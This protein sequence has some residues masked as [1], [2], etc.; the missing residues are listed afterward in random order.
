M[1]IGKERTATW[2][3]IL[4]TVFSA[5]QRVIMYNVPSSIPTFAFLCISNLVGFLVLLLFKTGKKKTVS[6][7]AMRK[8]FHLAAVLFFFNL[9]LMLGV[10][11]GNVLSASG[12]LSLFFV[13]VT[14][15]LLILRKRVSYFS[16]IAT[17]VAIVAL[18]LM[19][20]DKTV[21]RM[22]SS[23]FV[24]ILLSD[25]FFAS[26]MVG[27]AVLGEKEDAFALTLSMQGFFT[28]LCLVGWLVECPVKG[29]SFEMPQT[30]AF[31]IPVVLVGI[32]MRALF[33]YIQV[34]AQQKVAPLK[35]SLILSG[36]VVVALIASPVVYTMLGM[37]YLPASPFQWAGVALLV[38]AG[39]MVDE[40]YMAKL[41]YE[42]LQ[43]ME[44]SRKTNQSS[45]SKKIVLTTLT[46][47]LIVAVVS[48][49]LYFVALRYVHSMATVEISTV[50]SVQGV[51]ESAINQLFGV[52]FEVGLLLIGI[53]LVVVTLL[54]GKISRRLSDPIRQLESDVHR[55][56]GGDLSIRTSVQTNDEIGSL[57]E[58]FNS[59]ADSLQKYIED[60]KEITAKEE[61]LAGELFAA[62]TIQESM[63]PQD[64]EKFSEGRNFSI[65]ATMDPAKEVGGDFYDY[66]MVDEDH[67]CLVIAD[68]SGKG[69]P[70]S[71]FMV[72]TKTLIKLRTKLG[73]GPATIL[74]DVNGRLCENNGGGLF[75]TVWLALIELSTGKG[76]AANAGHEHPVVR[77][78]KNGEFQIWKYQHSP[79]VAT[80]EDL[81]FREHEFT[82]SPGDCL[83]VYTDGVPEATNR[84]EELFGE[85]R[86]TNALNRD[87]G[88]PVKELLIRVKDSIDAF[89]G[90]AVQFDDITMLG[91]EYQSQLKEGE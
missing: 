48:I 4:F 72:V 90:D 3:L 13:F 61:R 44:S 12:A 11:G 58:S 87:S 65:Y 66:F 1:T 78:G 36:Q 63:L 29:L 18:T 15:I 41:G 16:L 85:E 69:I 80:M 5:T 64:F 8:G 73:G 20:G 56:S 47:A 91:F 37:E 7:V 31:W 42:D 21:A 55:I 17:L 70:A 82:L 84:E 76:V 68:V 81:L 22:D 40:K 6:R 24:F 77:R 30:A 62:K 45:V 49:V 14:P 83:F 39:F 38:S 43:N 60:M 32:V 28:P 26:Y 46:F 74:S 10:R 23:S 19:V 27:V 35:A 79:A 33:S 86:L 59:M 57:A 53:L 67:L 25:F 54:T 88:A 89:V 2:L 9:F 50:E 34:L 52:V 51:L 71:L 75:V